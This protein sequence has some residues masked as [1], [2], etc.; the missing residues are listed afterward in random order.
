MINRL[1]L[2]AVLFVL[3]SRRFTNEQR[4]IFTAS[5]LDR[6]GALPLR[7]RIR[8]DETGKVF[9]GGKP[10]NLDTA[11]TLRETAKAMLRNYARRQVREQVLFMAVHKGVFENESPEQG[12]FAKAALWFA[13]EEDKLYLELAGAE[14]DV[15]D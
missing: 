11:K 2:R 14:Q 15:E 10:L 1:V 13:Q 3:R 9:V 5:L 7:A 4:Q 8:V 6:I 12:L